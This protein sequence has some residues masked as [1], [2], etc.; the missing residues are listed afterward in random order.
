MLA[1]L[2]EVK[3]QAEIAVEESRSMVGG[4]SLP[5]EELPSY[6][7]TIRPKKISCEALADKMR[8]FSSPVIAHIKNDKIW[9]D[10]R[11]VMPE[12][13]EVLQKNLKEFFFNQN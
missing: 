7:V 11:T 3:E 4:G 9:M 1:S 2:Q 6:A 5:G 12:E 13:A 8:H 10:M